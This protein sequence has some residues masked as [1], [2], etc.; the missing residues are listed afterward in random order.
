MEAGTLRSAKDGLCALCYSKAADKCAQCRLRYY[1]SAACQ[2]KDWKLGH[3]GDCGLAD[4]PPPSVPPPPVR[5]LPESVERPVVPEAAWRRISE[6]DP[7]PRAGPPRGLRNLGNSCYMNSV[8]QG[9]YHASPLL[10]AACRDHCGGRNGSGRSCEAFNRDPGCFRCDLEAASLTC[11]EL[12][13]RNGEDAPAP[14]GIN[15]RVMLHGLG[16][17]DL[18]GQEGVVTVLPVASSSADGDD[19]ARYG[20]RL[21]GSQGTKAVRP[22]NLTLRCRAA[23]GP[24]GVARWLPRLSAEFTLG[25][26]EDAHEFLRSLLRLVEDEELREHA[27][28]L[29][30]RSAGNGEAEAVLAASNADLTATPS[31]VFGGL[32]VSTCTCTRRECGESTFSFEPFMDLSLEITEATDSVEDA[33]R[34]FTAPERLDKKNGKKCESC[35]ETVRAR[36]QLAIYGS[37]PC[38]VLHL[39]RFRYGERGKV[40]RPVAFGSQLNVRPFLCAGAPEV[41]RPMIYELRAVIVHLD[42]AGFS[43]FGHYVAYVRCAAEGSSTAHKWYLLDDS[44]TTEVTEAEVLRQ[45]AYL[46]LYARPGAAAGGPPEAPQ[47]LRKVASTS[48]AAEAASAELPGKC[49][50][51]SGAVCSYFACS[52][53]LCTRCYQE[54]HGRR[55]PATPSD[56]KAEGSPAQSSPAQSSPAAP[57]PSASSAGKSAAKAAPPP[58]SKPKKVLPN[59]QCPCGSGLKFKKCHGSK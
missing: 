44:Q 26:Q 29:Q 31:R 21:P 7:T 19:D 47:P 33:L 14:L 3:K 13:P 45:Q 18:N 49:R 57:S 9:L 41:G 40:T 20:V 35:N 16:R 22:Q 50:G 58:G 54:E 51:R 1:C 10:F 6:S 36:K 38:L 56:E 55:P 53:G 23:A 25:L 39:K 5:L 48:A 42:K 27:D 34:L 15:D 52:G 4:L 12:R 46:L 2:E 17:G 24:R 8:L 28:V 32:L 59:E 30:R 11:F 43:H 37:P